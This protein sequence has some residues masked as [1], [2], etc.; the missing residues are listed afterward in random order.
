ME[1]LLGLFLFF[2]FIVAA[3]KAGVLLL[4]IIFTILG[5][6]IGFFVILALIPLGIGLLLIPAIIIGVIVVIVKCI[7]LIL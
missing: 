6:I 4:K 2:V 7:Q 5:S 3:F 1:I